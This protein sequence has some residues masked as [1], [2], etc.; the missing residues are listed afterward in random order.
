MLC[1]DFGQSSIR[2]ARE[3]FWRLVLTKMKKDAKELH[4]DLKPFYLDETDLYSLAVPDCKEG[5][6]FSPIPIGLPLVAQVDS[7][8]QDQ[9]LA[10]QRD[11][12]TDL[13][14]EELVRLTFAK[15]K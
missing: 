3:E 9:L 14:I 8:P 11:E 6:V 7:P 15:I 2:Q 13:N 12:L 1:E 5:I 10:E 4:V